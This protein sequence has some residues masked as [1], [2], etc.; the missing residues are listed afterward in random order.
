MLR[1]FIDVEKFCSRATKDDPIE[2]RSPVTKEELVAEVW[3][4]VTFTDTILVFLLIVEF[5]IVGP[6]IVYN[7]HLL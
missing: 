5:M 4:V 1:R 2:L 6:S 3:T 7:H